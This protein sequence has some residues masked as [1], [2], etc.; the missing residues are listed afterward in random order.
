MCS[1]VCLSVF[2]CFSF[3]IIYM[4][5]SPSHARTHHHSCLFLDLPMSV[6]AACFLSIFF[7]LPNTLHHSL[8]HLVTHLFTHSHML[9]RSRTHSLTYSLTLSLS[10]SVYLSSSLC[11]HPFSQSRL[12]FLPL[13]Q[14][15]YSFKICFNHSF[16]HRLPHSLTN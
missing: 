1:F 3:F 16:S 8:T 6:L 2:F 14:P 12:L 9:A 15:A 7:P 11:R 10:L 4:S 13:C 5:V